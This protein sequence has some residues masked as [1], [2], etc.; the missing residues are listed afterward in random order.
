MAKPSWLTVSPLSGSGNGNITNSAG[1]HTGRVARTGTVTVTGDNVQGGPSTY[2][3]T[4]TP[5]GEF[6]S[7]D[8]GAEMAAEK[9]SCTVSVT[10]LSN[11]QKL[12]FSWVGSSEGV[13]LP[14]SYTVNGIDA[15]NG[16]S[17]A[18]DPGADAQYVFDIKLEI[19][20]NDTI[21]EVTRTLSVT[22]GTKSAQIVIKQ[23]AGDPRLSVSPTSITIPQDGSSVSVAVAANCRWTVS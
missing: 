9:T 11:A 22:T 1:A 2:E 14:S 16:S 5:K 7:F 18:N 15:T 8:N 21:E 13:E 17:I 19:P 20:L 10:G 3:V 4:Q 23:A 6:V 12:T